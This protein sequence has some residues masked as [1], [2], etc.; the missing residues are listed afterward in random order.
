[1]EDQ[2]LKINFTVSEY[3]HVGFGCEN[4]L[5]SNYSPSCASNYQS[6]I[7]TGAS[8]S[9]ESVISS[10]LNVNF[11]SSFIDSTN[12]CILNI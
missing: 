3:D 4:V 7:T 11:Q 8:T 5:Q 9:A 2:Q 10:Q 12:V 6:A 1:M